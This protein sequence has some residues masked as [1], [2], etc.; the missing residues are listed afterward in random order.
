MPTRLGNNNTNIH[1]VATRTVTAEDPATATAAA[2]AAV[3]SADGGT[4]AAAAAAEPA[5]EDAA[6]ERSVPAAAHQ[7]RGWARQPS[8][9]MT[10]AG[11]GNPAIVLHNSMHARCAL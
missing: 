9:D 1:A 11:A 6:G 7:V 3:E 4:A 2:A 10:S 8:A 5:P